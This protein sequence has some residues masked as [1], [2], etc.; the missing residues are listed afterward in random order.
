MDSGETEAIAEQ[1][2]KVNQA[3]ILTINSQPSANG[4]PSDDEVFGWGQAGGYVYQ[5]AYLEFF[6]CEENVLALLQVLGRFP[7]VNFQVRKQL[8]KYLYK[9]REIRQ[10]CSS[11]FQVVNRAGDVNYTN[12]RNRQPIAVTWGVFPG[13]EIIQPTIVDP[14]AFNQWRTEAFGLWTEQWGKLYEPESQSRQIVDNISDSYLLV[15]LVDNDFPKGNCIW[16]VIEDMLSRK[17][18]NEKMNLKTTLSEWIGMHNI[19]K[20]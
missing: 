1:L 10:K 6:S 7:G 11:L 2:K 5:K 18:L 12:M 8:M 9:N 14:V 13:R 3:G 19:P 15:N 17:K 16:D 4:V 20:K